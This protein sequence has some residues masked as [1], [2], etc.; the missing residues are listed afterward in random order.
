MDV[1]DGETC[2]PEGFMCIGGRTFSWVYDNRKEF[3]EFTLE[4]MDKPTKMFKLWKTYCLKQNRNVQ[5]KG[6]S[7]RQGRVR[8]AQKVDETKQS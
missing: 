4:K 7:K 3:V 8:E 1:S 2:W 5:K 6:I